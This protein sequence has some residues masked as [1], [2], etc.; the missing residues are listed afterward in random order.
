MDYAALVISLME[1]SVVRVPLIFL[2]LTLLLLI[3][4]GPYL[5]RIHPRVVLL[6]II[7]RGELRAR[8][9]HVAGPALGV[10]GDA[11]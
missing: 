7:L 3:I 11:G 6:L 4:E 1:Y 9:C 8:L 2:P 10:Y 5:L